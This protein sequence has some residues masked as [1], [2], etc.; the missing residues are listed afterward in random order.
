M[1]CNSWEN[2]LCPSYY[3]SVIKVNEFLALYLPQNVEKLYICASDI[4]SDHI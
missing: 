4:L 3:A 1:F 2:M